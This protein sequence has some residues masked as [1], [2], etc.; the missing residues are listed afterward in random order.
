MLHLVNLERIE[1]N[2]YLKSLS[3]FRQMSFLILLSGLVL[4]LFSCG[5][6]QNRAE[7]SAKVFTDKR[8]ELIRTVRFRRDEISL[9]L[10]QPRNSS[11][12]LP[13]LVVLRDERS[14]RYE[15][16]HVYPNH[17]SQYWVFEHERKT[18]KTTLFAIEFYNAVQHLGL[19]DNENTAYFIW[20]E[21]M[22]S[23][24]HCERLTAERPHLFKDLELV[25]APE[26]EDDKRCWERMAQ[27]EKEIIPEISGTF[28]E[29]FYYLDEAHHR[30]YCP[31]FSKRRNRQK[32]PDFR[33]KVYRLG[34]NVCPI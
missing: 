24:L 2:P 13:E 21:L 10:F 27:H 18:A 15:T 3:V 28:L 9:S 17:V 6:S 30:I 5:D 23:V 32:M 12:N 34:C 7:V 14:K 29:K 19:N 26:T 31:D 25:D 1:M 16:I 4:C 22:T 11:A 33:L 8:Y 20:D